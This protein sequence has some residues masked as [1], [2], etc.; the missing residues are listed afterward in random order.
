MAHPQWAVLTGGDPGL[1]ALLRFLLEREGCHIH[2][3]HTGMSAALPP[4]DHIALVVITVEQNAHEV[5]RMVTGLRRLGCRAPIMLL[6]RRLSLELKRWVGDLG[7]REIVRLPVDP[8]ELR[9]RLRAALKRD[10]EDRPAPQGQII[11]AGGWTLH[12]HTNRLS[13]GNGWSLRLTPRETMLLFALMQSSGRV[14]SRAQLMDHVWGDDCI[15][16]STFDMLMHRLRDKIA[17]AQGAARHLHTIPGRGYM[18][19]ARLSPR[20]ARPAD[21]NT[22]PPILIVQ[23]EP[24]DVADRDEPTGVADMA[25]ALRA[26][27]Y[28]VTRCAG[29]QALILAREERPFAI[30]L[31]VTTLGSTAATLQRRLRE[32]ARTS[33]IPVIAIVEKGRLRERA[34]QLDA[35]DYLTA[36]I[37]VDE[38]LLRV[39][40]L[41]RTAASAQGLFVGATASV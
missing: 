9:T 19:D 39:E 18:F 29:S 30:I 25:E 35:D 8:A 34:L 20:P 23:D 41:P 13:D 40:R 5:P 17:R 26:A 31:D 14:V 38:L 28:R 22:P 24:T 27:D 21:P 32:S 4:V 16:N 2:E 6:N 15:G 37:D 12:T 7:I 11:S 1:H 3:S 10:G 33:S 36:P